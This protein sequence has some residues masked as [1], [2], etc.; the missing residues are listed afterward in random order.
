MRFLEKTVKCKFHKN[1][2]LLLTS[3]LSMVYDVS[4]CDILHVLQGEEVQK[5]NF[6]AGRL[7]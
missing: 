2:I 6:L 1:F 7:L 3:F 5:G 4:N